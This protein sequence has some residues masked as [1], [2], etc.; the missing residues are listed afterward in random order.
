MSLSNVRVAIDMSGWIDS[1]RHK[2]D[3]YRELWVCNG[4]GGEVA[5][6]T[7]MGEAHSYCHGLLGVAPE[8]RDDHY[9]WMIRHPG[10]PPATRAKPMPQVQFDPAT[11]DRWTHSSQ[12]LPSVGEV[13]WIDAS[14]VGPQVARLDDIQTHPDYAGQPIFRSVDGGYK[15]AGHR[16]WAMLMPPKRPV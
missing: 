5:P 7:Y 9:Y 3:K 2:P 11:Q 15:Y 12:G 4:E 16:Y 10:K 14:V 6:V 1:L 8:L 13:V